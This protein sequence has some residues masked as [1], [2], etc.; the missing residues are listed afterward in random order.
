MA[1]RNYQAVVHGKNIA[2]A[3]ASNRPISLKYSVEICREIRG[4]RLQRAESFLNNV[5]SHKEFLPLRQ[6]RGKI[7]HRKGDSQSGVKSGRYP[8]N[9]CMA[10]LDLLNSAKANADFKGMDA[11][12]LIIVHA[13]A[14]QGFKRSSHQPKG[15]ISGK[16]WKRKS[17]HIEVIV[18]E[19]AA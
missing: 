17:A 4:K 6:Y 2:R 1:K 11:E 18:R 8:K 15:K 5:L 14:S 10:F 9:A 3:F 7:P 13:F 12:N 16:P 19:I